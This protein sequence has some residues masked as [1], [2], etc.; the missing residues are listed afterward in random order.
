LNNGSQKYIYFFLNA[1]ADW[2]K[3]RWV[4]GGI[5]FTALKRRVNDDQYGLIPQTLKSR[6]NDD[7]HG[8]MPQTLER[9]VNETSRTTPIETWHK[10]TVPVGRLYLSLCAIII[11]RIL[12]QLILFVSDFAEE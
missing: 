10:K 7:R 11:A 5:T 4:L 3:V 12:F 9:R 1:I 2:T 8:L 6:V